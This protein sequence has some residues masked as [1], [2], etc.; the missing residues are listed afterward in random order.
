MTGQ[1]SPVERLAVSRA[2]MDEARSVARDRVELGGSLA[3]KDRD[4]HWN[5]IPR[6]VE[7]LLLR[8]LTA[9]ADGETVSISKVPETLTS[10]GAAETLGIS[11]PTLLKWLS[12]GRI[13]A[14]KVGTR[15][16]FHRDEGLRVKHERTTQRDAAF[17]QL[18]ELDASHPDFSAA[19][20]GRLKP[21]IITRGTGW[22]SSGN[23]LMKQSRI[24]PGVL[25]FSGR[26]VHD[27]HVHAAATSAEADIV[28]TVNDP[29][30]ITQHPNE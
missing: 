11:R 30:E 5:P 14:F 9:I 17:A 6:E 28:L 12:E 27:Y 1:L 23:S 7:D 19:L 25:H 3:L 22:S 2:A 15:T 8:A 13:A 26:D 16:R 20:Q 21:Q 10:T 18:R 24:T 29:S 4:G